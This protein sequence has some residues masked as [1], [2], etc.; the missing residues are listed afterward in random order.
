MKITNIFWNI[1]V[2]IVLVD[3]NIWGK[4]KEHLTGAL[5]NSHARYYYV[6]R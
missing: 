3:P 2:W 1:S 4:I 5:K 6:F